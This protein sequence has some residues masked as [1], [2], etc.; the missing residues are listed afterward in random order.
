M[1]DQ[2]Y[3]AWGTHNNRTFPATVPYNR[4]QLLG[5]QGHYWGNLWHKFYRLSFFDADMKPVFIFLPYTDGN[6]AGLIDIVTGETY[7]TPS[8]TGSFIYGEDA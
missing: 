5:T 2:K 7:T 4:I 3:Y 1:P 6:K 8:L